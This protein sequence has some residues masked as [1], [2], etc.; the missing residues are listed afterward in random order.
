MANTARFGF[1]LEYTKDIQATK[2]FFT[3]VLGLQL[4]LHLA[5]VGHTGIAAVERTIGPGVARPGCD[6]ADE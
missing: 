6:G 4:D 1:P 2:R 3:D 5:L